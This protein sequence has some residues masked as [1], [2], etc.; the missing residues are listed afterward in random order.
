MCSLSTWTAPVPSPQEEK[1]PR[2]GNQKQD[3]V[4]SQQLA[5]DTR[6]D[7]FQEK[8]SVAKKPVGW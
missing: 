7:Y 6:R 2:G 3:R 4:P 5:A 8:N 1:P